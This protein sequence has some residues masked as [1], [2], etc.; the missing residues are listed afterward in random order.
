MELIHPVRRR[1]LQFHPPTLLIGFLNRRQY[2][3]VFQTIFERRLRRLAFSTGIYEI[4]DRVN[5][6]V[7]V[8]N[9]VAGR[10]PVAHIRLHAIAFG[11]KYVAE[12]AA[13]LGVIA[14]VKF[15]PVHV[16]EIKI[17]R[18]FAAVDFN[19]DVVFAAEGIA[20]RLQIRQHAVFHPSKEN[21][22][23][24][25]ID[26]AQLARAFG[27]RVGQRPFRH[28]RIQPTTHF[29]EFADQITPQINDVRIDV[30]V[31]AATTGFLLQTPVQRKF[32]VRQPVLRVTGVE[33][34][35]PAK[36]AFADHSLCQRNSRD[37]PVIMA[38]HVD[39]LRLLCRGEHR[40]GLFDVQCQRFFAQNVLPVFRR[41]NRHLRV[42]IRRGDDVHDVNQR[43]LDNFAPV[44]CGVLPAELCPGRLHARSVASAKCVQ[45]NV[46]LEV[47]EA[48]RLPPGI[49]VRLAHE[50]V[51]DQPDAKS[52][53]HKSW[54][55]SGYARL[56]SE[57]RQTS[58]S[59]GFYYSRNFKTP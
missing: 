54:G 20:R 40:L 59:N 41:R 51:A 5:E 29:L 6:R 30:A 11:N 23:V 35:N 17:N 27:Q 9:A 21:R 56:Y 46:G 16:F 19:R 15:Q 45:L 49:R 4:G 18:A 37:A 50:A 55:C 38:D 7:F 1:V 36:R 2:A 42:K 52:S 47:E 24:R 33:M 32:R 43:R 28:K 26:L 13:I 22:R 25:H 58:Q 39:D 14:V 10:P 53:R 34:I 12:P 48:G 44:R 31:D 3:L 8:A 57:P